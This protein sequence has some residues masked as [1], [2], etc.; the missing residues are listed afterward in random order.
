[1]ADMAGIVRP[2]RGRRQSSRDGWTSFWNDMLAMDAPKPVDQARARGLH[3]PSRRT[4][5]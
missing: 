5:R 2:K 4:T 3:S 1:M